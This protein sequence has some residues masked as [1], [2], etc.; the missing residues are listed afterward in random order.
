MSNRTTSTA[1]VRYF[2]FNMFGKKIIGTRAAFNKANKGVGAPYEQLAEMMEKQPTFTFEVIEPKHRSRKPKE[3]YDGMT[4][5]W[6]RDYIEMIGDADFSRLF[7]QVIR[8]AKNSKKSKYPLA[9]KFFLKHFE[10]ADGKINFDYAKAKAD[11]ENYLVSKTE[12]DKSETEAAKNTASTE[13][14]EPDLSNAA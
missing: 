4:I 2:H 13:E 11:V 5:H 7:E 12:L 1:D 14:N 8:F 6:M 10:D 3:T 9:K